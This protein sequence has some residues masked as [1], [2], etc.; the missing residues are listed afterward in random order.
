MRKYL[1][2]ISVFITD[3][4]EFEKDPNQKIRKDFLNTPRNTFSSHSLAE[5]VDNYQSRS[6]PSCA[7]YGICST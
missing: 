5:L 4:S 6:C 1:S 7:H 3:F 2:Y